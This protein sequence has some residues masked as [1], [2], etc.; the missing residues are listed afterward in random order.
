VTK[1]RRAR[2][3]TRAKRS[4][5]T[6]PPNH[7][8]WRWLFGLLGLAIG[9]VAA[10]GAA[11]SVWS[12]WSRSGKAGKSILLVID[13]QDDAVT[14]GK[15]LADADLVDSARL[16]SLYLATIGRFGAVQPGSHL[17]PSN[18]SPRTLSQCLARH[19]RRPDVELIIIEGFDH[20]R[21]ANRL[22]QAGVCP[23]KS[24]VEV[25]RRRDLLDRLGIRGRDGEGYLFPASYRLNVDASPEQVFERLVAETRSRLRKLAAKI[26]NQPFEDLSTSRGWGESEILTLASIVEKE[27]QVDEERPIIASVFFNRIDDESFRPRR[28]LQSDPTAGY[29]CLVLGET[30]PSCR[31]YQ[32]RIVP[33]ML[34][35]PS[36][37]YNTYRHPG[38]PPGPIASPG[39]AS[40]LAVLAPAKTNYLFFVATGD[41]RHRFSNS[42]EEHES[43]VRGAGP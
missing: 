36:N 21:V 23:A 29:G 14:I 39:E 30:I 28:M 8:Y 32:Q 42:Y 35:D 40:V 25:V 17:F 4:G 22:E 37:P 24:F 38:L 13:E 26:G 27:A 16:M 7:W 10:G 9:A 12:Y 18:A 11:L 31:D 20:V 5:A 2:P 15:Q 19:V 33:A 34:R 3:R 43:R 6:L 41:G 1:P